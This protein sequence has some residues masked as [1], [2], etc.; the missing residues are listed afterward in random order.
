MINS[1]DKLLGAVPTQAE[2]ISSWALAA[3]SSDV[4]GLS[5][6]PRKVVTHFSSLLPSLV[7]TSML[8]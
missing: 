7:N 4:S 3:I 6:L 8:D 2:A 5:A 1:M